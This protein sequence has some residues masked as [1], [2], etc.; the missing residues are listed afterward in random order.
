MKK[1]LAL[2]C[3]CSISL[4]LCHAQT[5]KLELNR[6]GGQARVN[7]IGETNRDYTLSAGDLGASNW[8]FLATLTL[9]NS[10]QSWY[11]S[12]SSGMAI[13]YYRALKL[14]SPSTPEH[15]DDFRLIDHQG[16]SRSLYYYENA[17]NTI[18]FAL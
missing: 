10:N 3:L 18:A 9:T 13:R 2:F 7:I 5:T 1:L 17:T 12:A 11:D 16:K 14:A 15:A 8:N 6:S 4:N